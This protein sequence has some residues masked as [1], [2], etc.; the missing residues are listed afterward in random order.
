MTTSLIGF[1]IG[2]EKKYEIRFTS[3]RCFI[4]LD[5]PDKT[6]FE[7]I[8]NPLPQ[9]LSLYDKV[10]ETLLWFQFEIIDSAKSKIFSGSL[11]FISLLNGEIDYRLKH[12]N[13]EKLEVIRFKHQ[14][15]VPWFS[16]GILFERI[17]SHSVFSGWLIIMNI[18]EMD[19]VVTS[20]PYNIGVNYY[21]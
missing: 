19:V 6:I 7:T 4:L 1:L 9:E 16:Y 13:E 5:R 8:S 18:F 12:G 10:D 2:L 15:E 11:I 21:T 14:K 20:S 17:G 3:T